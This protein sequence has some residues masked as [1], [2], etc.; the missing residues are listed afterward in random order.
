[1]IRHTITLIY[2]SFH[3]AK[4]TFFINL[5]GLSTALAS[6]LLIYLWIQDEL[7]FDKFHEKDGRLF[8]VMENVRNSNGKV[9]RDATPIGM[10]EL[11]LETFP[12]VDH[13]ATVTPMAWFPKFIIDDQGN[14]LKNE[15]KFA[16]KNFFHIFSYP[17]LYG[18]KD[19]VLLDRHSIVISE[20]LAAKLYGS[21]DKAVGQVIP[22]ELSQIKQ[23][24]KVTGV[25]KDIPSNSSEQFEL[26]LPIALLGEIMGFDPGEIGPTGPSTFV[27]LKEG[28][29]LN[30]FNKKISGLMA[31]R[32][33]TKD[34]DFL[35]TPYSKK[36]LYGKFENGVQVETRMQY[37]KLFVLLALL[38][39]CIACINFMNLTTAKASRRMKEI[40]VKKVVGASR[41]TLVL[42]Y[43]SESVLMSFVALV[44]AIFIAH[45]LLP[46]FNQVTGKFLMF[47][48]TFSHLAVYFILAIITGILAGSYPALYLSGYKA[49]AVL[50][51]HRTG[52]FGELLARKGLVV[53][54]FSISI[55]AIVGALVIYRQMVF[56]QTKNLGY[57]KENLIYFELEGKVATDHET[58]ISEIRKT[59]GVINASAMVGNIVGTVGHSMEIDF[60][61]KIIPFHWLGIDDGMIET[62][63]IEMKSGRT[64]SRDFNDANRIIFNQAAIDAMGISDPIG[65]VIS[66]GNERVEII[67]VT[68]NF[69][70]RSLHEEIT[71][72][73]FRL[74]TTHLWNIFVKLEEGRQKQTLAN[75]EA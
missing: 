32:T 25:F 70:L 8:Q 48:F 13:A 21:A 7:N 4:T 29:D 35:A 52:S 9:T 43:I 1:M 10:A 72:L 53:F 67:G 49:V 54:Q 19:Q 41:K 37:V 40:G 62:L 34:A 47:S 74:E 6:A 14:R 60:N 46:Q 42:Q 33:D 45:L 58:F 27:V 23:E 59:P 5:I 44:A 64:F 69:H 61:N 65:K 75:I 28:A 3:R 38:I 15:S 11:L 2:R 55:I 30:A 68:K 57:D 24:C 56:V 36:Y 26:V 17:L 22:W 39:L 20:S 18:N 50:K 71:P 31:S 51:G 63:G 66:F 16:G 73:A 12:E